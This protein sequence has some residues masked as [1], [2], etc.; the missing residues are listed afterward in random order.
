MQ[1][2]QGCAV[3]M[4][5]CEASAWGTPAQHPYCCQALPWLPCCMQMAVCLHALLYCTVFA[6]RHR[7]KRMSQTL[8]SH[9]CRTARSGTCWQIACLQGPDPEVLWVTLISACRT[10]EYL[11]LV[12]PTQQHMLGP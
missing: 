4:V 12:N 9:T 5:P 1:A 8:S 7:P 2:L 10:A 3:G 6:G 11:P